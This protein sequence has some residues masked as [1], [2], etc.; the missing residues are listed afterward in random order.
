MDLVIRKEFLFQAI[1]Q[2]W[3]V[4]KISGDS[5]RFVKDHNGQIQEF[6]TPQFVSDFVQSCLGYLSRS[7]AN[8]LA[9]DRAGALG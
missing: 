1:E 3:T 2:G 4:T 6:T 8:S 5:Y 9:S 7:G